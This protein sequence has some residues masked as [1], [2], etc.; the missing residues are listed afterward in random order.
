MGD[1]LFAK[2]LSELQVL[3]AVESLVQ[4]I[5]V[6]QLGPLELTRTGP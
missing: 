5:R 3:V 1:D 4:L 6:T 2:R